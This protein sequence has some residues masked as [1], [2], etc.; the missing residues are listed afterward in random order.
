MNIKTTIEA[1]LPSFLKPLLARVESSPLG[2]RL[3]KG[4]FWSLAGA[5]TARGLGLIASILVAR[6][7]GKSGF[8]ELGIIQ[9]TVG[10]FGIFAGF[11]L[12][13]T[14][15]KF[16]AQYR[17]TDPVKAGHIRALS[18]TFA[19]VT[20]GVTSLILFLMAPW[21]AEHTLAAPQ[22]TGLLQIGSLILFLTA[23]NG[24]Q[25]G[26][27]SGFEAF[28]T[29]SKISLWSGLANFPLMVGGV[30]LAGLKGAVWGMVIATGINWLLNHIA[31][32]K[33]CTKAGVPYTHEG[34]W[35]D[36][37]ILWKFSLPA[38]ISGNFLSISDWALN[39][40]L[41]NAPDGYGEMGLFNAAKQ[42]QVF[43]LFVPFAISSMTLPIL[44]N[45]LGE[46][47]QRQYNK[48]VVVNS[49]ALTALALIVALLVAL[50]SS[51]IMAAYGR[52]FIKGQN[53]LL[54]VCFYSC[55]YAVNIVIGQV[56][57]S[58][59]SSG[60]AMILAAIR[61]VILIGSFS[62]ITPKNAYGIALA[63]TI[64]YVSMTVYQGV[65]S[66]RVVN[67]SFL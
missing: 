10:M 59:G 58:T 66:V 63:Y 40:M 41:V 9:S 50:F 25:I 62:I 21:L 11:G 2:Y 35:T 51:N 29:I 15:T 7:L 14:A 8:G 34:C 12:G 43:I 36:K 49:I 33:E 17:T 45:L 16:I 1:V 6:M 55:W 47:N 56:L 4:M 65:L 53:V 60:L 20:S 31:I 27:L 57:W 44:S 22:L 48:M 32:R 18:S 46:G 28:K 67:K 5:V 38:V 42:W 39:A 54:L 37:D 61:A 13:M 24:A 26:A 64:T 52:D 23:V 19:W 3:A 30:Y